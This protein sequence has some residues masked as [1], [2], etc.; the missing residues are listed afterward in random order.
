M[1][2]LNYTGGTTGKGKG[3][4]HSHANNTTALSMLIAEN[5]FPRGRGLMTTPLFHISGIGVSNANLMLGNTLSILPAYDPV[6]VMGEHP[7]RKN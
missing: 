6:K 2:F 5:F 3:V 1:T 4:M 7:K